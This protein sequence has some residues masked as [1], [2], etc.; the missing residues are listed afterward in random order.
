MIFLY[1]PVLL[2]KQRLDDNIEKADKLQKLE[3]KLMGRHYIDIEKT[4]CKE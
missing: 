4:I 3:L 1:I 2:L